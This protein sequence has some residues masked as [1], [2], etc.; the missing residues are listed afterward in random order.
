MSKK[1]KKRPTLNLGLPDVSKFADPK[2][3]DKGQDQEEEKKNDPKVAP[4]IKFVQ[5]DSLQE[6]EKA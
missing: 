1:K 3:P 5:I 6:H 4:I 2:A